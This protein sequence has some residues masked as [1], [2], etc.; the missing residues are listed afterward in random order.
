VR[1]GS[2][3]A[4]NANDRPTRTID[5]AHRVLSDAGTVVV[6]PL[7][8][9]SRAEHTAATEESQ[10]PSSFGAADL[11]LKGQSSAEAIRTRLLSL[12]DRNPTPANCQ[13]PRA[14]GSIARR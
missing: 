12:S 7:R 1:A 6:T 2:A 8:V 5:D 11:Q 9:F 4:K 10:G 13:R 14:A 3:G